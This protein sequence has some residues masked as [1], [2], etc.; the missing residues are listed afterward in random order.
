M[1]KDKFKATWVSHSSIGD[2][3]KCPRLYYL[4]AMYKDPITGH[5]INRVTPP[6]SRGQ[7][8]HSVLESLST[9]PQEERFKVSPLTKF[10]AEWDKV[11]GK[12]GGFKSKEE[13][14]NY[15]E[16]ARS[17]IQMV[18]EN[19]GPLSNKAVKIKGDLPYYWISEDENIILCGKIDWLEY[20][21]ITDSV[22]IVDFKTGREEED[23]DSLQLPI[24]HLLV[25]NTQSRKVDRA[26]YWYLAGDGKLVEKKLP[27]LSA[28]HRKVLKIAK[29]IQLARQIEHL[30]CPHG[31]CNYCIPFEEIVKGKGELV[32]V[33]GYNQ[34]I[35]VI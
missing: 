3:L 22:H 31:G 34:D 13:E 9:L 30:K 32:G 28:A 33:S 23:E 14:D 26:S 29:R 18:T 4:R 8:V 17:M 25:A 19:P 24:Y 16:Q 35:Y 6:L 7:V 10:K 1:T 11:S 20:L 21:P 5:K 27:E 12:R 2:F 15:K